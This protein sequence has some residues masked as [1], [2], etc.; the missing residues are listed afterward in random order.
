MVDRAVLLYEIPES[1]S[2]KY[3]DIWIQQGQYYVH[4]VR[5]IFL[6]ISKDSQRANTFLRR[7]LSIGEIHEDDFQSWYD[8]EDLQDRSENGLFPPTI[9]TDHNSFAA[10]KELSLNTMTLW[11]R[12]PMT[13]PPQ[14]VNSATSNDFRVFVV[15]PPPLRLRSRLQQG[16]RV[17]TASQTR[18]IEIRWD[19]ILHE[20]VYRGPSNVTIE[21]PF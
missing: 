15:L 17:R 5:E 3:M 16:V 21:T 14:E 4:I 20:Q 7:T 18:D 13:T 2:V 8:Y 11:L 12:Y 19:I 6:H 1:A 10:A 9:Q